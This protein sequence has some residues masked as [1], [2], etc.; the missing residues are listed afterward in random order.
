MLFLAT[1]IWGSTFVAQSL[2]MDHV[3][4]F[5]FQAIRCGIGAIALLPIIYLFDRKDGH[6]K[7]F[8][9]RFTDRTLWKAAIS[10][11]IPL[12]FAT[13]LQQMGMVTVDAGKSGFLTAMYIVFVPVFRVFQHKKASPMV[14]I[15]VVIAV[16]GLYFLSCMGVTSVSTGDLLLLACAVA[17]ALQILFVDKYVDRVDGLRLNC[18][19]AA[20][21]AIGSSVVMFLTETP[22]V[23]GI[24]GSF[25][26]LCYAGVLS[27]GIAYSLQILGQKHLEPTLAS[28]VMSLESVIAVLC[29]VIFLRETMTTWE[30]LGCILVFAAVILSQIPVKEKNTADR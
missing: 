15:S 26:A 7:E 1:L 22:T 28:L 4:P 16:V 30:I 27:M 2:G 11:A 20:I 14:P 6:G 10:C 24:Q 13:N 25:W 17:F 29:G 23:A 19:Q 18:L 21:C 3:G 5:T 8:W 9:V 12:F